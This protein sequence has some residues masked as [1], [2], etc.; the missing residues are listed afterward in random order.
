M[1][2]GL[3]SPAHRALQLSSGIWLSA[4][5]LA[6]C[7]LYSLKYCD[8]GKCKKGTEDLL[9]VKRTLVQWKA[10]GWFT[11]KSKGGIKGEGGI[12]IFCSWT[13]AGRYLHVSQQLQLNIRNPTQLPS[14]APENRLQP[15]S[16]SW[17]F[18]QT[19]PKSFLWI[20]LISW[21]WAEP[22]NTPQQI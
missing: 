8:G 11:V 16:I 19:K 9:P 18:L 13:S 22:W 10:W 4:H 5:V 2:S 1:T 17:E 20:K 14:C 15:T 3:S 21:L 6:R 7:S 12:T